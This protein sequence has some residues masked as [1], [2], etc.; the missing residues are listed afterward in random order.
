MPPDTRVVERAL[1]GEN[2]SKYAEWR[3]ALREAHARFFTA[4][5]VP[6]MPSA[7]AR[8]SAEA[9]IFNIQ[10]R[11]PRHF[12]GRENELEAIDR[13]WGEGE[14]RVA[15]LALHGMRGVG[16]STVAA[17]YAER[18]RKE[19]RA[20]WWIRAQSASTLRTDLVALGRRLGWAALDEREEPALAKTIRQ[21]SDDG[22]G[23][24]LIFDNAFDAAGLKPFLPRAG[25][26][27][28]LVTST[29]HNWRGIGQPIPI[30]VWPKN[31]GADYVMARTG[32][33]SELTPAEVL[34]EMLGGLPLAHEQ[35]AAY[36]ERLDVSFSEY[37][38]RFEATPGRML[39]D[40]RHAPIEYNGGL[41]VGKTFALAMEEAVKLNPAA[42]TL[43]SYAAHLP[44]EPLPLF[45][46]TEGL[47][48]ETALSDD[49]I[50][51]AIAVL[52][53]F[54]LV[55]RIS[56]PDERDP[57]VV[58]DA[59]RIH[60]LVKK[61][62]EPLLPPDQTYKIRVNLVA[63]MLKVYPVIRGT[64]H[65]D[66]T[67]LSRCRLLDP[68]IV[69]LIG[70]EEENLTDLA[71]GVFTVA[72]FERLA[73]YRHLILGETAVAR[74]LQEQAVDILE[75]Q[76][77]RVDE[78]VASSLNVLAGILKDESELIG[79]RNLY[80]RAL[81]IYKAKSG[82]RDA[83]TAAATYNL[84]MLLIEMKDFSAA[85]EL[86]AHAQDIW[87][88][89]L[90]IDD[91]PFATVIS[92]RAQLLIATG[93]MGL[94]RPLLERALVIREKKL[95]SEHPDTARSLCMLADLMVA[96]GEH[97]E[98]MPLLERAVSIR[99]KIFGNNHPETNKAM[100]KWRRQ[101][102]ATTKQGE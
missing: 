5:D 67:G 87:G 71:V 12:L 91:V 66:I 94:A 47:T 76:F 50:Y 72:L 84:A 46:F 86:I 77:G 80:E 35:A 6:E 70:R 16:K 75:K 13:A 101:F 28:M 8:R 2:E 88:D 92:G 42:G 10:L 99:K 98:A 100:V 96:Q 33:D 36:C 60:R 37:A 38:K 58:T 11:L 73:D 3:A 24:L 79:A 82:E 55:E 78:R 95:G 22:K 64:A 26:S 1:F 102:V 56:I 34:A 21:L 30:S 54:A 41:T 40:Q 43:I 39:D 32:R 51:E 69:A 14:G 63:A 81:A 49:G 93:K 15:I 48:R 20:I 7:L 52:R 85:Q 45:L 90:D 4:S 19:Y 29:S 68:I 18:H 44:P 57:S 62:V 9:R 27:R 31:V 53:A 17:A 61:V 97:A 59:I 83:N 74:Q 89:K 25:K 65:T 23:I